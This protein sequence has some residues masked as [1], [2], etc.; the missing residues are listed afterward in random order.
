[1]FAEGQ[2]INGRFSLRAEIGRGDLGVVF[3]ATE[4]ETAREFAIKQLIH[5]GDFDGGLLR[6]LQQ[7]ISDVAKLRHP[8]IATEIEAGETE[9]GE[10]Y[11]VRDFVEGRPLE[12]LVRQEAPLSV[13]RACALGRQIASA[14]EAAHSQGHLHGD[15]NLSNVLVATENGEE[16]VKVLGFGFFPFKQ[17]RY[18]DLARLALHGHDELVGSA[19]YLAPERVVGL[20]VEAL[21]GRSDLYSLGVILY[22]MLSGDLPFRRATVM[23]VLL[24][25]LFDPPPPLRA[26]PGLAIPEA[27]EAMV[28]RTLAKKRED[29]PP[30]ATVLVDH[31][32]A[33]EK[34][35]PEGAAVDGTAEA[36]TP[37]G[38][39]SAGEEPGMDADAE[40]ADRPSPLDD[41]VVG[42]AGYA[43]DVSLAPETDAEPSSSFTG[44]METEIPS[45]QLV[46]SL[47]DTHE[48]MKTF[49][50][51]ASFKPA[52]AQ[53]PR[54]EQRPEFDL[55]LPQSP[56][57]T[58]IGM[59]AATGSVL[60]RRME[61]KKNGGGRL[62]SVHSFFL[63]AALSL[64]V[65]AG[66][67]CGWVLYTGRTYWFH[68]QFVEQ[69]ISRIASNISVAISSGGHREAQQSPGARQPANRPATAGGPLGAA[70]GSASAP[71]SA[72]AQSNAINHPAASSGSANSQ[73]SE[74]PPAAA[75]QAQLAKVSIAEGDHYFEN[76]YYKLAIQA[77]ESALKAD[78]G[79]TTAQDGITRAEK[80]MAAEAKYLGQ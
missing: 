5:V 45:S 53:F 77:Y 8:H 9:D 35:E 52:P 31:L 61:R 78:P 73:P 39:Q 59:G 22:A 71:A 10:V 1:M 74:A 70:S 56:G 25:Q 23:E 3:R 80:A 27:L 57:D 47:R 29:R 46:M 14:L 43:G 34:R 54:Q 24:A 28:T 2:V 7:E 40:V 79:N 18:V 20:E 42:S 48:A 68:P 55:T 41:A 6:R 12:E 75:Q 33:W 36:L 67:W 30:T 51:G 66:G 60:F 26:R 76:G 63:A 4:A 11:T 58:R 50:V 38:I 17:A 13:A 19:E 16:E 21:D 32:H 49:G 15:L 65:L 62:K 37:A 72:P 69:Q 64:M 44:V